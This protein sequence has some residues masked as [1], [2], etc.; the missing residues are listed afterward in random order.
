MLQSLF[1]LTQNVDKNKLK[2]FSVV[3]FS[4]VWCLVVRQID[5]SSALLRD[6]DPNCFVQSSDKDKCFMTLGDNM[7]D[8]VFKLFSNALA[9]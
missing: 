6:K 1:F 7:C 4:Q 2:C 3:I 9:K 8:N 5:Y